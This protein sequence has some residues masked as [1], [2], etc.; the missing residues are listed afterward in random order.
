MPG[1][2]IIAGCNGAGKTTASGISNLLN[3][4][5]PLIDNW[6][7]I[8]NMDAVPNIIANGSGTGNKMILHPDL[9]SIF[10]KAIKSYGRY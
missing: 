6:A 5:A 3:L 9:W 1:L 8:D 7:V 2:Y 10:S 4:Y